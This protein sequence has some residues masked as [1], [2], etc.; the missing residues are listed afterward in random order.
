MFAING[1]V[2]KTSDHFFRSMNERNP[3]LELTMSER[4]LVDGVEI[5]TTDC[6]VMRLKVEIRAGMRRVPENQRNGRLTVNSKVA[7]F[8]RI[9][10][11][12][13]SYTL[14]FHE[15]VHAKYLTFQIIGT[16]MLEI[17]ELKQILPADK[18]C[19][20]EDDYRRRGWMWH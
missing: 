12:L 2:S 18:I 19:H 7:S 10:Q 15:Q 16:S 14:C 6:C 13:K 3:W 20:T 5:V 9:V 11:P 17:N 8:D 1:Q 4:T